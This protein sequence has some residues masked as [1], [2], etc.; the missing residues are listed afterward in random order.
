MQKKL[1]QR[2]VRASIYYTHLFMRAMW[3]VEGDERGQAYE[4][5]KTKNTSEKPNRTDKVFLSPSLS[6]AS[7]LGL[8]WE[9]RTSS[10][11]LIISVDRECQGN[12][13][14][15]GSIFTRRS[16]LSQT[17]QRLKAAAAASQL[18]SAVAHKRKGSNNA[19]GMWLEGK[20][21]ILLWFLQPRRSTA[22]VISKMHMHR[23]LAWF[24]EC[25]QGDAC[26]SETR[27]YEWI[28]GVEF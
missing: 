2:C 28:C 19:G 21:G 6:L 23:D 13:A 26:R 10:Y 12:A 11:G 22:A 8:K 15:G 14:Q 1:K 20:K 9:S 27:L 25:G 17:R 7:C 24:T 5:T 3:R 4:K 16:L 18:K